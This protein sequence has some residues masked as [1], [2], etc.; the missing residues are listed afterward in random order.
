MTCALLLP[1]LSRLSFFP[2][3][4]SR[5]PPLPLRFST[6][7]LSPLVFP[8][9]A[10]YRGGVHVHVR[11]V[12]ARSNFAARSFLRFSFLRT[13]APGIPPSGFH[14]PRS[15][16]PCPPL[17][18]SLWILITPCFWPLLSLLLP[19]P[20]FP[21]DFYLL[22]GGCAPGAICKLLLSKTAA[23]SN[24]VSIAPSFA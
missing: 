14:S 13:N 2:A 9:D 5:C 11:G 20:F 3:S 8:S 19:R 15:S 6:T 1:A 16:R 4:F 10:R 12:E 21:P 24:R 23:W 7:T 18:P 22:R 17:R